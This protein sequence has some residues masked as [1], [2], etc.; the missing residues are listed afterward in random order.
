MELCFALD[1]SS[2]KGSFCVFESVSHAKIIFEKDLPGSFTHSETLLSEMHS[3]LSH[4]GIAISNISHWITSS[5]P[6]SFTGLRIAYAT[7]KAFALAT[8][9]P[10]VTVEGPEARARA[11]FEEQEPATRNFAM[12]VLS[13]LTADKF[14]VSSFEMSGTQLKKVSEETHQG[15]PF[16]GLP[17]RVVLAEE[18]VGKG[19]LFPL[20]SR[21]LRF[22]RDLTSQKEYQAKDLSDLSPLYLGSAHF[23]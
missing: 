3:L 17:D 9:K 23:D 21:H 14:V 16:S 10:I 1:L 19:I 12:D 7:L 18:R 13:Y 8:S 6:G 11:F 4:H 22:F 2:P 5:G 15:S 20:R